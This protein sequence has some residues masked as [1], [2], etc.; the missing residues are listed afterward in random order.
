MISFRF[1][2][3]ITVCFIY[4]FISSLW[5]A[6]RSALPVIY[7]NTKNLAPILDKETKVPATLYIDSN[8]VDGYTSLGDEESP[9]KLTIKGRGNSS[10]LVDK[11]PYKLKFEKKQGI[12]GLPENKHY[13][14]IA[15]YGNNAIPYMG[16]FEMGRRIGM[17]WTPAMHLVELVLNGSYEGIYILTESVKIASGRLDIFKQSDMNEDVETIPYGWLVE[18]DQYRGENQIILPVSEGKQTR[19]TYHSPEKLS[20][21]QRDWL[22]D[23]FVRIDNAVYN[24]DEQNDDWTQYLDIESFAKYFI[25]NEVMGNMDAWIGSFYLHKDS[26][27]EKWSA[28]PLWDLSWTNKN[29]DFSFNLRPY[30]IVNWIKQILADDRFVDEVWYQWHKFYPE[31]LNPVFEYLDAL[32]RL[33]SEDFQTVR[34][35]N[36]RWPQVK[37]DDFLQQSEFSKN[38]IIH[39]ASRLNEYLINH[40]FNTENSID[41]YTGFLPTIRT[42]GTV[43]YI[44]DIEKI[45]SISLSDMAGR[46][47]KLD[48]NEEIRLD[49]LSRGV[50][51]ISVGFKDGKTWQAKYLR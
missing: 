20:D 32:V 5:A 42:Q 46:F 19:I 33:D 34:R 13:A 44:A 15:T 1:I 50:Y 29:D 10:W 39:N 36:E 48:I 31:K 25:T 35:N 8:G 30:S 23:E 51:I 40:E 17:S 4:G 2:S 6:N 43:L 16:G 37:T 11:K 27:E 7:I 9:V 28:G 22:T 26:G 12:F 3:L 14:L 47:R 38:A 45:A 41:E 18:L 21:G 24:I 49:H